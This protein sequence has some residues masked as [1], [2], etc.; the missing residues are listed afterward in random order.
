M[1]VGAGILPALQSRSSTLRLS[2][3]VHGP[4]GKSTP[5]SVELQLAPYARL[6]T[7]VGY[8]LNARKASHEIAIDLTNI[9]NRPNEL[10]QAYNPITN[11]IEMMY[12]QGFFVIVYYRIRF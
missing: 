9:T 4:Q 6:D 8:K 11:Q 2:T 12:Q 1:I 10:T 5:E 3:T 7:R